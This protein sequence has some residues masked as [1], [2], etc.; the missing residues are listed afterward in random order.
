[1]FDPVAERLAAQLP[2]HYVAYW[3][4]EP[5]TPAEAQERARLAVLHAA[6][7][8]RLSQLVDETGRVYVPVE[9]RRK[10]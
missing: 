4:D 10:C 8:V 7:Q 6:L 5:S 2:L 9:L 3:V 1:M